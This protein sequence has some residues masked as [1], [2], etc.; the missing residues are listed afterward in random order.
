MIRFISA[1]VLAVSLA[2]A[3]TPRQAQAANGEEVLGLLAGLAVLAIIANELDDDDEKATPKPKK[4]KQ[5]HYEDRSRNKKGYYYENRYRDQ[6]QHSA[7][8]A[9]PERCLWSNRTNVGPP[10]V[11]SARCLR[12]AGVNIDRLPNRCAFRLDTDRGPRRVYGARCLRR[13]GWQI[14]GR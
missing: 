2:L 7:R 1:P 3:A 8:R 6:R 14:A 13:S 4:K 12:R 10:R 11:F 5:A 9:L